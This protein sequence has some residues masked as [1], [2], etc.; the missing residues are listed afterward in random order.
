MLQDGRQAHVNAQAQDEEGAFGLP[1]NARETSD[2]DDDG[3]SLGDVATETATD[4]LATTFG[5]G[6]AG[7][8][9]DRYV[10][11]SGSHTVHVSHVPGAPSRSTNYATRFRVPLA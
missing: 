7:R 3:P 9:A 11:G 4:L 6:I 5:G 2:D 1:A 8:A 10:H